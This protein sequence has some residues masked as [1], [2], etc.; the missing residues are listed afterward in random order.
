MA[1]AGLK[2]TQQAVNVF[3]CDC[4]REL[5]ERKYCGLLRLEHVEWGF[6]TD[7]IAGDPS[8]EVGSATRPSN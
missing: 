8:R 3:C 6:A 1:P 4:C 5:D 2:D 7:R